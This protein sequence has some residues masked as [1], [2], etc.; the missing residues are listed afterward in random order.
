[1][2]LTLTTAP[3]GARLLIA[4]DLEAEV[5]AVKNLIREAL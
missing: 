1:M 4:K 3:S 5:M 2:P